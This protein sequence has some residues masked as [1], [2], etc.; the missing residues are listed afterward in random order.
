MCNIRCYVWITSIKLL[1]YVYI[2]IHLTYFFIVEEI[3]CDQ[4]LFLFPDIFLDDQETDLAIVILMT[5]ADTRLCS[6][7]A[8]YTSLHI[9]QKQFRWKNI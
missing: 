1:V 6:D 7:R 3:S 2:T 4:I 5:A 9:N 8:V